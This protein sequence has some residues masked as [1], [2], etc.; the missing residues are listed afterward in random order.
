MTTTPTSLTNLLYIV[1]IIVAFISIGGFLYGGFIWIIRPIENL[2]KGIK[3]NSTKFDNIIDLLNNRVVP[4]IDN[5]NHEFSPNSGKS[6]KDQINRIDDALRLAELRSKLIASNL[7]T[8]TGVY[9]C[10]PDGDCTWANNAF[11]DMLGLSQDEVIGSGW[12]NGVMGTDRLRV[13]EDW[14]TSIEQDIPYECIFTIVNRR[15]R[16]EIPVRANAIT[17]KSIADKNLGFYGTVIKV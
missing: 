6:I 10:S 5:M 14:Q 7:L 15:T 1:Q 2:I 16:E 17:H 12:L 9:E 13:W 11:C 3:A 4:F 8:T